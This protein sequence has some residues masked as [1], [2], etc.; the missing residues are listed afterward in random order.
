MNKES[1]TEILTALKDPEQLR[2]FIRSITYKDLRDLHIKPK[3]PGYK[4]LQESKQPT[5][6]QLISILGEGGT[7][8]IYRRHNK[9]RTKAKAAK[10]GAITEAP[11]AYI[12]PTMPKYQNSMSLYQE[13]NA[14]LQMLKTVDNLQCRDG[15]LIFNDPRIRNV[16]LKDLTT[17]EGIEDIDLITLKQL[18]GIIFDQYEKSGFCKLP[19]SIAVH[20]SI[21]AGRNDPNEN[22]ITAIIDKIKSYHNITGVILNGCSSRTPSYYQILNFE[23]YDSEHNVIGFNSPYMTY[24]IKEIC[25]KAIRKDKKGKPKLK[26]DG[27]PLRKPMNS[28]MIFDVEHERNRAAV[29]NV[30]IIVALIETA[31]NNTP[32]IKAKTLIERNVQLAERLQQDKNPNRL[33]SR[34]FKRTWELLRDKTRLKE[35]YKGIALP[36]PDKKAYIPTTATLNTM[37]FKFNHKGKKQTA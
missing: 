4:A 25:E 23:Y 28:Y 33:L 6:E 15:Q 17:M 27:T 18:Y 22:E 11:K 29:R 14:Y 36:D 30:E 3:D 12:I 13:G 16:K 9:Y 34:V 2:A 5:L 1:R 10:I 32:H 24:V 7:L 21:L 20:I 8:T 19:Q 26:K 37:V 31:G 35:S